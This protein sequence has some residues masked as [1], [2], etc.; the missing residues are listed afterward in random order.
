MSPATH[1]C[2]PSGPPRCTGAPRQ[3]SAPLALPTRSTHRTWRQG[4]QRLPHACCGTFRIPAGT[5]R[6]WVP[7]A[8]RS[9][10]VAQLCRVSICATSPA[11]TA[12]WGE[13]CIVAWGPL[14]G[15]TQERTQLTH[16]ADAERHRTKSCQSQ[17]SWT[18]LTSRAGSGTCM[19]KEV[20]S[21]HL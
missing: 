14:E 5:P 7:R 18:R 15:R 3:P 19:Q 9:A 10:H 11:S 12:V 13:V 8:A 16:H 1:A 4:V 17:Q 2:T 21:Q 20:Q 6:V